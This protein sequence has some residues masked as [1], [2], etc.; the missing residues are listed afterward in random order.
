[1]S[2]AGNP[3]AT[4]PKTKMISMAIAD[5]NSLYASYMQQLRNGGLFVPTD[6]PHKLGEPVY[7]MVSLPGEPR[8]YPLS[9]NVAWITPA[10]AAGGRPQGVGIHFTDEEPAKVVRVKIQNILGP[11]LGSS[12]QTHT[13]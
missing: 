10:G 2:Q 11:L 5:A 1:M 3:G 13:I 8:K 7:M 12:K 4:A 6:K 9:G